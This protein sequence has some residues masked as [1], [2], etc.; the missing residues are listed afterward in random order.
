MSNYLNT[1]PTANFYLEKFDDQPTRYCRVVAPE[2]VKEEFLAHL[3]EANDFSVP[4]AE[5]ELSF[6]QADR[7]QKLISGR[8]WYTIHN[9]LN[10]Y[11]EIYL[12][13]AAVHHLADTL[14]QFLEGDNPGKRK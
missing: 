1:V 7:D 3:E 6:C 11:R 8:S 5:D 13:F 10:P 9:Q 12:N 14:P 2:Y 4:S